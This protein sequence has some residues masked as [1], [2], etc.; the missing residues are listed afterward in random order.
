MG[1]SSLLGRLYVALYRRH[2]TIIFILSLAQYNQSIIYFGGI[3]QELNYS[4]EKYCLS[5][6]FMLDTG[7][8]FVIILSNCTTIIITMNAV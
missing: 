8:L 3:Q 2:S 5:D 1:H 4:A 6:L 7:L